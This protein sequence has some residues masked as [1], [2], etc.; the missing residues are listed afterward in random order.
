MYQFVSVKILNENNITLY[1]LLRNLVFCSGSWV[2]IYCG[3]LWRTGLETLGLPPWT[4]KRSTSKCFSGGALDR[5]G[6]WWHHIRPF[7]SRPNKEKMLKFCCFCVADLHKWIVILL[8]SY[9]I[10]V[11][12]RIENELFYF[13]CFGELFPLDYSKFLH[14]SI[15]KLYK[16]N[17]FKIWLIFFF[18]FIF[19]WGTLFLRKLYLKKFFK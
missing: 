1:L 16:F 4:S 15:N 12:I 18:L 6:G 13:L 14:D 10:D 9:K 8:R 11:K 3:G 7:I 5:T 19:F 17:S 2:T